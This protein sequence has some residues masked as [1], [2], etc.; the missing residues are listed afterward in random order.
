LSTGTGVVP[1]L[2]AGV[3]VG[4]EVTIEIEAVGRL[5]NEVVSR[6]EVFVGLADGVRPPS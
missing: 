4:D 1:Q 3:A 2:G 5:R 6:P